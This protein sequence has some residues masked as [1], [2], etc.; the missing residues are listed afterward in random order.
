MQLN[1]HLTM[2]REKCSNVCSDEVLFKENSAH[3]LLAKCYSLLASEPQSDCCQQRQVNYIF[4][5]PDIKHTSGFQSF[6][7][8][9]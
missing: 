6:L 9:P 7:S 5:P 3:I 8:L 2:K 4:F 1:G